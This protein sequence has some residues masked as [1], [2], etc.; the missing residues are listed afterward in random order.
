MRY[1]RS[2][3]YEIK[4]GKEQEF[5]KMFETDVL[6]SLRKQNG[7]KDG[8]MLLDGRHALGISV[9][10]DR[11]SAE[12]YQSSGFPPIVDRLSPVLDAKPRVENY[13]VGLSTLRA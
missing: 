5:T 10:E 4:N 7:F 9:W 3:H 8:L 11:N 2:V 12:T 1:A 6:P 13:Q